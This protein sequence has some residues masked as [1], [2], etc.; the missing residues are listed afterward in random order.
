[1]LTLNIPE[2]LFVLTIDE[3]GT[4][5]APVRTTLHYG[6]AGALL[7]EL[8][9]AHK[10]QLQDGRLAPLDPTPT[11]D[12][13]FDRTLAEIAAE[14]APG[15]PARWVAALGHKRIV[16]EVAERLAE[17]EVIHMEGKRYRWL[18]PAA[19]YSQADGADQ[20]GVK[21]H[22]RGIVL[23]GEKA[24]AQDIALLSLLKACRLLRLLFARE[25]RWHADKEVDTLVQ[26]EVFGEAV[27]TVVAVIDTAAVTTGIAVE[28]WV[29]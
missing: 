2:R 14:E 11:G 29:A 19:G 25:E 16:E 9:L 4:I 8:A 5:A 12:A 26:G 15:R 13:W 1:M 27:A 17:R 20:Y 24:E 23:A 6:L 7:A 10:V 21:Q 3:R 28:R 18:I 22:L